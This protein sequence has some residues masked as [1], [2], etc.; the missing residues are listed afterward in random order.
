M[1][2]TLRRTVMTTEDYDG[3]GEPVGQGWLFFAGTIL[4]LAG[5]MRIFDGI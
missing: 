2:A 4:G 3:Y 1:A 5:I